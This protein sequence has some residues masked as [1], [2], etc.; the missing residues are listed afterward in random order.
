MPIESA[1]EP[2]KVNVLDEAVKG[3]RRPKVCRH[4]CIKSCDPKTTNYCIADALLEAYRGNLE[5]GF[6]FTGTNCGKVERISSVS[7]VFNELTSEYNDAE[8]KELAE[9][10]QIKS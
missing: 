3:N 1:L 7:E 2:E 4:H 6:V 10:I 5:N 8:K 9:R